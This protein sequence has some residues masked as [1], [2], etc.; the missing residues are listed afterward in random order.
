[1]GRVGKR[2]HHLTARRCGAQGSDNADTRPRSRP[3]RLSCPSRP[4]NNNIPERR[5]RQ[6]DERDDSEDTNHP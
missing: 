2:E 4:K 6:R 3:Y 1:M 5:K